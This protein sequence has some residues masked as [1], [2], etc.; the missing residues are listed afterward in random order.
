MAFDG[1]T[2]E[3]SNIFILSTI[4]GLMVITPSR[5]QWLLGPSLALL[6][7]PDALPQ[8][9]RIVYEKYLII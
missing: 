6:L 2:L 5:H 9:L 3:V 4:C 1:Q 7:M 8:L